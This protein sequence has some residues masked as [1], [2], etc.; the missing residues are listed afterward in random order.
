MRYSY[1]YGSPFRQY[2]L[3]FWMMKLRVTEWLS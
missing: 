3:D 1:C 2:G